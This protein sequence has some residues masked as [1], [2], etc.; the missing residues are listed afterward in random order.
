MEYSSLARHGDTGLMQS[1]HLGGRSQK[2]TV[3]YIDICR[4]YV[5]SAAAPSNM[6][7]ASHMWLLC[8]SSIT[9][10]T[11]FLF[12]F[13]KMDRSIIFCARLGEAMECD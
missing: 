2:V 11:K 1:Q 5:L 12:F 3:G 4:S 8:T 13:S 9:S 7:V 6:V 10:V